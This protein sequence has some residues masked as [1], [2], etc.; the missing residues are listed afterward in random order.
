MEFK[1]RIKDARLE[2]GLTQ[3]QL[4][5]HLEK[6][7]SAVRMWEIG[8]SKPD[9]DTLIKLARFFD[10][11]TDYLL[12]LSDDKN[13]AQTNKVNIEHDDLAEALKRYEKAQL[14][15]NRSAYS[16]LT[17]TLNAN[18]YFY[19]ALLEMCDYVMFTEDKADEFK[20][21]KVTAYRDARTATFTDPPPKNQLDEFLTGAQNQIANVCK[22]LRQEREKQE[23]G[24]PHAA[25]DEHAD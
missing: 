1:E 2:R 8:R 16:F 11:T 19:F 24:E 5:S 23:G 6:G 20:T 22:F 12:G 14:R 13:A 9:A 7:E 3:T 4:A 10:C 18:Q 25:Q 17:D 21:L 15:G